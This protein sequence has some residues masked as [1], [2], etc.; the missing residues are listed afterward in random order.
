MNS[1]TER[2]EEKEK[3][4]NKKEEKKKMTHLQRHLPGPGVRHCLL[5]IDDAG[6]ARHL[7]RDGG[8]ATA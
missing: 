1:V 5:T 2:H 8:G 3:N 6:I 7:G 4:N